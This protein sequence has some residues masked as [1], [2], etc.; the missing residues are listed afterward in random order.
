MWKCCQSQCCQFSIGARRER[1]AWKVAPHTRGAQLVAIETA[2][3]VNCD[4]PR[5][6]GR[7]ADGGADRRKPLR[8]VP[9]VI[10]AEESC[11]RCSNLTRTRHR[12]R[13][14]STGFCR[15]KQLRPLRRNRHSSFRRPSRERLVKQAVRADRDG[16][17]LAFRQGWQFR[18]ESG[19]ARSWRHLATSVQT[20]YRRRCHAD[21]DMRHLRSRCSTPGFS[22]HGI[23]QARILE[24][25]AV[26]YSR[27]SS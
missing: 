19:E 4:P 24:W 20:Q 21:P 6:G 2:V 22:A 11:A 1:A 18:K 3:A 5:G 17:C 14:G 13:G 7:G 26:S 27:R 16:I 23:F 8:H 25:G 10:R 15:R 12:Y 9:Y